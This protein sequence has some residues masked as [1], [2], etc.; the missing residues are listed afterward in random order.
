VTASPAPGRSRTPLAVVSSLRVFVSLRG[1]RRSWLGADGLAALAL[2]AIAVPSQLATSRLAGMPPVTGLYAFVAGTVMFALLGSNPQ[3]SVGADSTIAP[4]FA[5]GVAHLALTGSPRYVALVGLVAVLVGVLVALVG[6]LRCGWIA[7]LLS[8]PIITGFLAG[9]AI[10]I[11]V[12]Q[13]SDLLGLPPTSGSTLHRINELIRHLP[14]ANGWTL[15]IGIA[16]FVVIAVARRVDRR[17]PGAFVALIGSAVLVAVLDL[18]AHG[19]AVLGT[20]ADTPPRFG[21]SELSWSSIGSVLPLA[22]V[23][24]LVVVI[25]SAAT[26]RAAADQ[27]GY[28]IDVSRD[29]VGVGAGNV[30]AGLAGSFP[31]D[32]SPPSTAAVASAGGRTQLAAL[33]AAAVV[34]ALVPAAVLI[35]VAIH[36]F[37]A[38]ELAAVFRFDA[39]EFSLA[40]I[41]LLTVALIG[42][43]QG[44]GVAVGLAILDRTRLSARPHTHIM[45]RVP[46]TTSWEPLKSDREQIEVTGVL[47]VLYA[48]PLYFANAANF[49]TQVDKALGHLSSRPH[50]FVLDV[51]GMHDID[52]T[53]ARA[54]NDVL[55]ELDRQHIT[56]A[57]T[58][59]GNHLRENLARSGLLERIGTQHLYPSVDDAVRALGPENIS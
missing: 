30:L 55:D 56:F 47:V 26:T 39:W 23:V 15:A 7:E 33:G 54:L 8:D 50:V 37:H 35:F 17:L 20:V 14:E 41:T 22:A 25:Q 1:Y 3:M 34:V 38:R 59:A 24:A 12:S 45:V 2:V 19:V 42:V 40:V 27:G 10:I 46:G 48:S 4:L 28:D 18:Q 5:V 53:G 52:F 13:L 29:L 6:I 58:R 16:V 51:V 31:V 36:L 9:V 43:E 11:I 57:L 44:I 32:A 21:L 49:R